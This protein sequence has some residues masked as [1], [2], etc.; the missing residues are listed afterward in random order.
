MI[1]QLSVLVEGRRSGLIEAAARLE[2]A[3]AALDRK[4]RIAPERGYA[5]GFAADV[6]R[7]EAAAIRASAL[8]W[9]KD[10]P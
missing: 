8:N 7:D 2:T 5:Y 3:A 9:R 10:K 1:A 6:L 4:E